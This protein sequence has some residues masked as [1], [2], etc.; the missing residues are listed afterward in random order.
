MNDKILITYATCTGS[1]AGVAETIAKILSEN[2]MPVDLLPMQEVKNL[3]PYQAVVVGSGIQDRQWLPEAMRFLQNHH[4]ILARKPVATFSLCMT[5]AMKNGE[6]YRPE[7][8]KWLA[9]VRRIARPVS[10]GVFAGV[11]DIAKIPSFSDR[12]KFRLSVLFGVWS[13]GDHRDWNA[14]K[15]W[16]NELSSHLPI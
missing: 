13:E 6:K 11:L 16:T 10:E 2:G 4:V 15:A 3:E 8:M 5:L 1:T 14:I 7:I 12:M 9:L